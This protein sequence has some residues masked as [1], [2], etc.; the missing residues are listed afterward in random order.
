MFVFG[1]ILNE[2]PFNHHHFLLHTV[3]PPVHEGH[4]SE[5]LLVLSSGVER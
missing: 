3:H 2:N 1:L 4:L 5:S